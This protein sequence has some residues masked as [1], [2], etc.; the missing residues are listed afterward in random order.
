[1]DILVALIDRAGEIVSK[2]EL[3]DQVWSR[4]FVEDT[5]IRV[6]VGVVRKALADG[7]QGRRYI[8][9]IAGR[10]Y[11]FVGEVRR[12]END[13]N[14]ARAD[15]S[16]PTGPA[17]IRV[18]GRE[19]AVAEICAE[20]TT[21]KLITIVGPGGMGKTTVAIAVAH[22][23]SPKFDN[24]IYFV[25]L[26]P[27][28][29]PAYA[30][31]AVA[32]AIGLPVLSDDPLPS[33]IRS[34]RNRRLLI[35]LDSCEHLIEAAATI[36][37]SI[38]AAAPE[39]TILAT[40]REP[41]RLKR[42]RLHR[43]SPLAVPM[44]VVGITAEEAKAYPSV[45]LFTERVA[46]ELDGYELT[47]ED[48]PVVATICR[49]LDGIALAIELAAGRV[50]TFGIRGVADQLDDRMRLLSSGQRSAVPRHQT[51]AA[52]ISWSY[53]ALTE[54]EKIALRRLSIFP[55]SFTLQSG[56][57]VSGW[58]ALD[59]GSFADV[60]AALVSKSLMQVNTERLRTHYRL[61]DTT[62]DYTRQKLQESGETYATCRRHALH[63]KDLFERA[64]AS[65]ETQA[66]RRWPADYDGQLDD[67][68]AAL[69]A[70]F[71]PGGDA[72]V[73][74][75][76][77]IV[78]VPLW[79]HLSLVQECRWHVAKAIELGR[80]ELP[81]SEKMALYAALAMSEMYIGSDMRELDKAWQTSLLLSE[82]IG[83]EKYRARAIW[84]LA[85][86]H[87]LSGKLES[88]MS[89]ASQYWE[90]AVNSGDTGS[91]YIGERLMGQAAL[92]LGKF[93][94]ARRH[95]ETV[96]YQ[97]TRPTDK[98]HVLDQ[99]VMAQSFLSRTL[100]L[101]GFPDQAVRLMEDTVEYAR[102]NGH[103][104][105]VCMALSQSACHISKWIGDCPLFSKS[106]NELLDC[107]QR[108]GL[109][110]MRAPGECYSALLKIENG[111]PAEGLVDFQEG[112]E[113]FRRNSIGLFRDILCDL[114]VVLCSQG[115][116]WKAN[117]AVDEALAQFHENGERWY[118][119]ECLRIKGE[120]KLAES[121]RS[122][123]IRL[124]EEALA[125]ASEMGALSW[126]LRAAMSLIGAEHPEHVYPANLDRLESIYHRFTEGF[127]SADLRRA[128]EIIKS[129]HGA[130]RRHC[131]A[132]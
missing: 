132:L 102:T 84:G 85:S 94:D 70:S 17:L 7:T 93:S 108:Y 50:E 14:E 63:I 26:S 83:D 36:A 38:A 25:D 31:S 69:T 105:S 97:Y 110:F 115:E 80:E 61:L 112:F 15:L 92:Y 1:M 52:A 130:D 67:L 60:V 16:W 59:A 72:T 19:R 51:L 32:A 35:V 98:L 76:L 3:V 87:I 45:Q 125:A 27:I 116:Y 124:F 11:V 128:A 121:Q 68:R 77:T 24:E 131:T 90:L 20:L 103:A 23:A 42:E 78:S 99:K 21:R 122:D 57:S 123:A 119:P 88:S 113:E 109:A 47:D 100:W 22:A 58:D 117:L 104:I 48:A 129:G 44:E 65:D 53:D 10:G 37:D 29:D 9:T 81:S 18:I 33:L 49:H 34:L 55:A 5:N 73:G 56:Q 106:V 91:T 66:G 96:L 127:E 101:T 62:R 75:A 89:H 86:C 118:Y 46:S 4:Q 41:L 2:D 120:I 95:L 12:E 30:P 6:H 54:I 43:L 28:T 114:A 13:A 8:S 126:E 79:V 40:S 64:A 39:V 107:S 82:E 74:V 71:D 111:S